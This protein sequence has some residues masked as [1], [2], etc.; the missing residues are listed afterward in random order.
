MYSTPYSSSHLTKLNILSMKVHVGI[1][2]ESLKPA[3]CSQCCEPL[4]A[5]TMTNPYFPVSFKTPDNTVP[6]EMRSRRILIGRRKSR[7]ASVESTVHSLESKLLA[8]VADLTISCESWV[9]D[10]N[11]AVDKPT[12]EFQ[13]VQTPKTP[14]CPEASTM[15][16]DARVTPIISNKH[17]LKRTMDNNVPSLPEETTIV[18]NTPAMKRRR[19]LLLARQRE[20][21]CEFPFFPCLSPRDRVVRTEC[22]L[23]DESVGFGHA[24]LDRTMLP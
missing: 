1:Q 5:D 8:R 24:F 9:R 11:T 10:E 14:R 19:G 3:N 12:E 6:L 16:G 15:A 4:S 7:M 2:V 13:Y 17:S 22:P 20:H 21:S 18:Y 23:D